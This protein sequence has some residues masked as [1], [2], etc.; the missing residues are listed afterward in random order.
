VSWLRK[1]L[2][3]LVR[4]F[5]PYHCGECLVRLRHMRLSDLSPGSQFAHGARGT[6]GDVLGYGYVCPKCGL[7]YLVM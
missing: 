3:R 4:P 7:T 5:L 1:A 2:R 6:L